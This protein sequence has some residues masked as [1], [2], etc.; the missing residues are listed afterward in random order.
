MSRRHLPHA[1]PVCITL[2]V[3]V[4]QI[5]TPLA[6]A[7]DALRQPAEVV[8]AA[9][10]VASSAWVRGANESRDAYFARV[11]AADPDRFQAAAIQAIE[12]YLNGTAAADESPD[13]F[14]QTLERILAGQ[15]VAS[16]TPAP[17]LAP[18]SSGK[19]LPSGAAAD[20]WRH[21]GTKGHC[22]RSGSWPDLRS[23]LRCGQSGR[24][25]RHGPTHRA[26]DPKHPI[27]EPGCLQPLAES[28]LRHQPQ[29]EHPDGAEWDNLCHRGNRAGGRK[30]VRRGGQPSHAPAYTSPTSIRHAWMSS[31][32]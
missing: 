7:A 22:C 31:M 16:P 1:I 30:T 24:H 2:I 18:A 11:A 19:H 3:L 27:T 29:P 12:A 6:V 23:E 5:L 4:V 28:H 17:T 21:S 8:A 15:G 20:F 25:R 9:P 14:E 26:H 32:V 10:A 13:A